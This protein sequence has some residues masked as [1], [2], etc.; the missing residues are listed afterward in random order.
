M[1]HRPPSI[2]C[3][4]HALRYHQEVLPQVHPDFQFACGDVVLRLPSAAAAPAADGNTSGDAAIDAMPAASA[5]A[6]G[7]PAAA[8]AMRIDDGGAGAEADAPEAD[9]PGAPQQQQ[10]QRMRWRQQRAEWRVV[11]NREGVAPYYHN[12]RTGESV[13]EKPAVLWTVE[14]RSLFLSFSNEKQRLSEVAVLSLSPRH[15]HGGIGVENLAVL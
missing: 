9:A 8:E 15:V 13:W 3:S 1:H 5:P 10:P 11:R 7:L 14:V 2:H 4:H 6:G 12:T